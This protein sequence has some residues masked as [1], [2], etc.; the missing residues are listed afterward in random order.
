VDPIAAALGADR[1]TWIDGDEIE[2]VI[3]TTRELIVTP[4][5]PVGIAAS[6]SGEERGPE[7][8]GSG[9]AAPG[10]DDPDLDRADVDRFGPS[11]PTD[12]A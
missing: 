11:D 6:A 1:S 9:P 8:S 4:G 7:P 3:D 2:L 5:P 12:R 10:P